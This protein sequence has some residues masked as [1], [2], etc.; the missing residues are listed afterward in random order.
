MKTIT[1]TVDDDVADVVHVVVEEL[2]RARYIHAAM[3]SPHEG[4][5]VIAEELKELWELVCERDPRYY[6]MNKEAM[7]VAAMGMRFMLDVCKPKIAD[8]ERINP[9]PSNKIGFP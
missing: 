7:Q 1:L 6:P 4:V 5:A 9:P 8:V 2:E 3:H